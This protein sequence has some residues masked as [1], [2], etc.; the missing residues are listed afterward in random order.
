MELVVLFIFFVMLTIPFFPAVIEYYRK[1]DASPL[2]IKQDFS[3]DPS[4]FGKS[5]LKILQKSL[6]QLEN[7]EGILEAPLSFPK[8]ER[9]M[10]VRDEVEGKDYEDNIVVIDGML[11]QVKGKDK[12]VSRREVVSLGSLE[13]KIP[14][15]ARALLVK[16]DLKVEKPIDIIRWIHVEGDCFIMDKSSLGINLYCGGILYVK[17]PCSFK[18]IFA[19]EINAGDVQEEDFKGDK[20]YVRGTLRSKGSITLKTQDRKMVIEGNII[21]DQDIHIEGKV[22]VKGNVFSHS[23]VIL[24]NGCIVGEKG[25]VKSVIGKRRVKII[26][27]AK[28]Y[29]YVHTEGE[30]TIEL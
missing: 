2:N 8:P 15:K 4:Y 5:F 27:N 11:A 16:G 17:A 1:K 20:A 25:K 7:R 6:K 26:K 12:F 14:T 3:K 9:L 30:G 29:G 28:I 13:I 21:S 18:R 19:K 10:F 22:W 24:L 23:G